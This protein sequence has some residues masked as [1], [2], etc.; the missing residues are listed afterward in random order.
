MKR[1]WDNE[2]GWGDVVLETEHYIVVRWD[3]DP[4]CYDQIPKEN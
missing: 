3:R 1:Y 4:W 2:N